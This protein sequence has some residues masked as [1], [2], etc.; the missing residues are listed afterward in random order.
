MNYELRI[1]NYGAV[2]LEK[3]RGDREMGRMGDW[4]IGHLCD[5][6]SCVFAALREGER[7][8]R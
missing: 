4:E 5:R 3:R 2:N 7:V 6:M 1:T 8:N